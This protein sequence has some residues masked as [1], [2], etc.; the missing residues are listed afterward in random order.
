MG[1]YCRR[2]IVVDRQDVLAGAEPF[3]HDGSDDVGVLLCHGFTGSPQS[4]RPW[5][6]HLAAAGLTVRLPLLPGHGTRWQDANLTAWTDWY[7]E[8]DAAFR[9]LSERCAQVFVCGLSMGGTLTL[10]L[11]EQHGDAVSGIVL[12]NPSVATLRWD[13]KLAPLLAP[14]LPSSAAIGSDIRKPG[15]VELAYART[16]VRA[17]VSLRKLWA[18]VRADLPKVTQPVLLLHSA[19]D[20][21]VEPVNT[22]IVL[23]GISSTDVTEIVLHDSYHVATLDN[24]APRIFGE[25]LSFVRRLRSAERPSRTGGST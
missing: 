7:G 24:D 3:A 15:G 21:V 17:F 11:A 20:H 5:A 1:S 9:E 8:V 2:E 13:A 18:V 4:L 22:E 12:V 19:E 14:I 23:A 6:E 16:P 25:S 10:R